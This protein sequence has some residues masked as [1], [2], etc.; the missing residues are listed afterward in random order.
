MRSTASTGVLSLPEH[1]SSL[2]PD[3]T[4][5]WEIL[6][7]ASLNDDKEVQGVVRLNKQL[8]FLQ[9][10][11]Y[12]VN[13]RFE[14]RRMGPASLEVRDRARTAE[15]HDYLV[16]EE[17]SV[18]H[19]PEPRVD[20]KLTPRGQE[21]VDHVVLPALHK[22][23]RGKM[24]TG[25]FV[26]VALANQ[27]ARD[28]DLIGQIH[29]ILYLDDRDEFLE[30]YAKTATELETWQAKSQDWSLREDLQM[31]AG[32]AIDLAN[33][34]IRTIE[35]QVKDERNISVGKH[36]VLWNSERLVKLVDLKE[37]QGGRSRDLDAQLTAQFE[38]VLNAL[39]V[40]CHIYN[41]LSLKT[42]AELEAILAEAEPLDP[43]L[44][45]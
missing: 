28:K 26:R 29:S 23:T 21:Y 37:N 33:E 19:R 25:T 34:A 31:V 22:H 10:E 38:R 42:E 35:P 6:Q 39:E 14:C 45:T 1:E 3:L 30:A 11:G 9:L 4:E 20:F 8:A 44:V 16:V 5:G 32:A 17:T 7:L 41:I 13:I 15:K 40:N 18:P 36:N 12:P 27:Y 24:Y 2:I 43:N